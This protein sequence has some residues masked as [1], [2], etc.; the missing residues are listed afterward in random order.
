[1]CQLCRTFDLNLNLVSD[2]Y[3]LMEILKE[4]KQE[5]PWHYEISPLADSVRQ[6][7]DLDA[8]GRPR[9]KENEV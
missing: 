3:R 2:K 9:R 5:H 1:M 8:P 4:I 6:W 7:F